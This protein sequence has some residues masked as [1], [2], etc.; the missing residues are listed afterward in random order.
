MPTFNNDWGIEN[1]K[2]GAYVHL[3]ASTFRPQPDGRVLVE[4]APRTEFFDK[5]KIDRLAETSTKVE[6]KAFWRDMQDC[7][8]KQQP[9]WENSRDIAA[10]AIDK[11]AAP[12]QALNFNNKPAFSV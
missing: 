5:D 1:N 9:L 12:E 2:F 8:V 7:I 11:A 3:N 6:T 4:K 10:K